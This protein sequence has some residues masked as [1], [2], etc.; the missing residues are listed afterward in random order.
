MSPNT[1]GEIR[2]SPAAFLRL[3]RPSDESGWQKVLKHVESLYFGVV[4][5]KPLLI[6]MVFMVYIALCCG[7]HLG[8]L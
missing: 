1:A 4:L 8:K 6:T 3:T 5:A 7:R 2:I